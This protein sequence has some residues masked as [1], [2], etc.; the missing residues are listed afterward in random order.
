MATRRVGNDVQP[1]ATR[2]EGELP[3]LNISGDRDYRVLIA[4]ITRD[5]TQLFRS[6]LFEDEAAMWEYFGFSVDDEEVLNEVTPLE[7]A[8]EYLLGLAPDFFIHHESTIEAVFR[9]DYHNSWGRPVERDRPFYLRTPLLKILFRKRVGVRVDFL[10]EIIQEV[11]NDNTSK[12]L[13]TA[14]YQ[15]LLEL[16]L[17][18][19]NCFKANKAAYQR[20]AS[21]MIKTSNKPTQEND[22]EKR[23]WNEEINKVKKFADIYQ[24][25]TRIQSQRLRLLYM[26][27]RLLFLAEI[28]PVKAFEES[29]SY[30]SDLNNFKIAIS[31]G[32]EKLLHLIFS[33]V[34]SAF[35]Y[36]RAVG[37]FRAAAIDTLKET[38][39]KKN[40]TLGIKQTQKDSRFVE[41]V[42]SPPFATLL[43][44]LKRI[45]KPKKKFNVREFVSSMN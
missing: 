43:E 3:M 24:R 12:E 7:A 13:D 20:L 9:Q 19:F 17:L 11:L 27:I 15:S 6:D 39:F 41:L 1:K 16:L 35:S 34:L 29:L 30:E 44:S 42:N 8:T 22:E 10:E 37:E 31:E 32:T 14:K 2:N 18:Q 4:C 25:Y 38:L 40:K 5:E 33:D 28:N 21:A 23:K 36:N 45:E 26:P